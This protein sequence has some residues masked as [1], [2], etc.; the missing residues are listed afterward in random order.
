MYS[1]APETK[2]ELLQVSFELLASYMF[3]LQY[4][5]NGAIKYFNTMPIAST[6]PISPKI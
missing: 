2:G 3:Q 5:T 6:H 1:Y 4:N